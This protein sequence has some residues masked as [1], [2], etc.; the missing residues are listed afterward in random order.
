MSGRPPKS[1]DVDT[2]GAA[3]RSPPMSSMHQM[4]AWN[5]FQRPHNQARGVPCASP[6]AALL[7]GL[8]CRTAQGGVRDPAVRGGVLARRPG[9]GPVAA[10]DRHHAVSAT[11]LHVSGTCAC[12]LLLPSRRMGLHDKALLLQRQW[13]R[14]M[15]SQRA[16]QQVVCA[17]RRMVAKPRVAVHAT[18]PSLHCV[19]ST[20]STI[21]LSVG[22]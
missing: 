5:V 11:S 15:D 12:Y 3:E 10:G 13:R 8:I 6:H 21:C 16:G 18:D 22:P 2:L 17:S 1:K 7:S 19:H 14:H 20:S 9:A 4:R